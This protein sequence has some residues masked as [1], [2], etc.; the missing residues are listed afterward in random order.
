MSQLLQCA[1]GR[2]FWTPPEVLAACWQC[3]HCGALCDAAE[4]PVA[5]APVAPPVSMAAA[6]AVVAPPEPPAVSVAEPMRRA[7][8]VIA[9]SRQS[10]PWLYVGSAIAA[11]LLVVVAL[12]LNSAGSKEIAQQ[13]QPKKPLTKSKPKPALSTAR[14]NEAPSSLGA[15]EAKASEPADAAPVTTPAVSQPP[16]EPVPVAATP[17]S[18]LP[19]WVT[20]LVQTHCYAC[21]D[22]AKQEGGLR[23]DELALKPF[24][25]A[26]ARHWEEVLQRLSDEE[27]PPPEKSSLAKADRQRLVEWLRSQF[28]F[29][30]DNRPARPTVRRMNRA[31]YINSVQ[32]TT[33]VLLN[34]EDVVDDVIGEGFDTDASE[35]SLSPPL[36]QRYVQLAR[37]LASELRKSGAPA[38]GQKES[39][40]GGRQPS[41]VAEVEEE[42]KRRLRPFA[43]A[44]FRRPVDDAKL[45]RLA[46]IAVEKYKSSQSFDDGMQLAAQAV[47]CSPQFL[48]LTEL[49]GARDDYSL[50]SKLSYFLWS[51]PPDMPLLELAAKEELHSGDNLRAQVAR[52]LRDPKSRGLANN[53]GAQWLGTRELGV[54]QPDEEVFPQYSPLLEA[55]MREETHLFFDHVLRQN[56]SI[57]TF[58]DADFTFVNEPLA[59]LYG[60]AN[61]KGVMFRIV[62]LK[63]QQ[64]RGGILSQG[65]M[66]SI[67]S[68]GVRS[69]PVIRGV[70]ILENI[71]GDPPA[72]PPANVPDLETDT[73]GT[74]TIREELAKHR[75]IESCNSCHRKIDPLG[76]ALENYDAIGQ[77][78]TH[79][80]SANPQPLPVDNLGELPDGTKVEGVAQLKRVLLARKRDFT[81]CLA[82][83]LLA[84]GCSRKLDFSDRPA[85][86]QIVQAVEADG[87]RFQSL[88]QAIVASPAF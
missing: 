38:P 27:M 16:S 17:V 60:I 76:F 14:I 70:W 31:E 34:P 12:I 86:E 13:G 36:F 78:R 40:F 26:S 37:R 79:Y 74:K 7:T 19:P 61:V 63:P 20:G 83:K 39:L 3:P 69:S 72:P 21:H 66:L 44:A 33:G 2:Q 67:T 73:R 87:Y 55:S 71:L 85:V 75:N 64:H 68:D 29:L 41:A 1:C 25:A 62:S 65:S 28:Q 88:V 10:S 23:L 84:Y 43:T 42:A 54:M 82:E 35:L 59:A 11:A 5:E 8:T 24:E 49:E 6:H 52:M 30:A 46:A 77:W 15:S 81:R 57:L 50:A 56:L 32:A 47:L 53:F 45:D 4:P 9:R 22:A 18:P 48:L 51:G 80:V 58:I